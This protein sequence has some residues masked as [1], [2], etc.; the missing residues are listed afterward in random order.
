MISLYVRKAISKFL[1]E[2]L[3]SS[4]YIKIASSLASLPVQIEHTKNS[5]RMVRTSFQGVLNSRIIPFHLHQTWPYWVVQQTDP[6]NP[7]YTHTG[8]PALLLN[9]TQR[10]WTV[11]SSPGISDRAIVDPR[12]LITPYPMGW[13]LDFWIYLDKK[14]IV[15]AT[16]P[17]VTQVMA[18]NKALIQ[19]AY[20]KDTLEVMSEAFF[21]QEPDHHQSLLL[22]KVTLKN[23]G[24]LAKAFSFFFAIRPFNP[25]GISPIEDI[26]YLS[27][28]A[29]V[30]DNR[31]ALVLDQKPHNIVCL[32]FED[33]DVS[34]H[35]NSWE[36]I[37]KTKC[38]HHLGSA[39]A[40]YKVVLQPGE[41]QSFTCKLPTDPA[42]R[43]KGLMNKTLPLPQAQL[44]SHQIYHIQSIPYEDTKLQ[45]NSDWDGL[46]KSFMSV[47][48]PQSQVQNLVELNMAH[49]HSFIE[50]KPLSVSQ[51]SDK[52]SRIHDTTYL[53]FALNR[54][55]SFD[56]SKKILKSSRFFETKRFYPYLRGDRTGQLL[57]ALY[58]TYALSQ[59]IPFIEK[60]FGQVESLVK[61]IK[62]HGKN[63]TNTQQVATELKNFINRQTGREVYFFDY[64]WAVAGLKAAAKIAQALHKTEE[65]LQFNQLHQEF[66]GYLTVLLRDALGPL[67]KFEY[68]PVSTKRGVDTGLMMSLSS[69]F[70]LSVLDA[71]DPRITQ[72]LSL[73]DPYLVNGLLYSPIGT[74]GFA[75]AQNCQLAQIY[76]ARNDLRVWDIFN[77]ITQ[78]ATSTGAFPETI[79]PISGKGSAGE[80]HSSLASASFIHLFRTMLVQETDNTL[81]LFPFLQPQWLTE[82]GLSLENVPTLFGKL[83]FTLKK[84]GSKALLELSLIPIKTLQNIQVFLPKPNPVLVGT[85]TPDTTQAEFELI[86]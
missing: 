70:P 72:T 47:R 49:L 79:H 74:P 24:H 52:S 3:S 5:A 31:L 21:K 64:F 20:T 37:L 69:I 26:T 67:P 58:D 23:T 45:V 43:L 66:S 18:N 12:G 56:M 40:E 11:I 86:L 75:I 48:L 85:L 82:E 16:L 30:V 19:T 8:F 2:L 53:I 59:D 13:S 71:F 57:V 6:Q 68:I 63:W 84:A 4:F 73:L 42:S 61:K 44:L 76:M 35:I 10:N 65:V 34:E 1:T 55:G 83:S 60:H 54:I 33:G 25:E 7:S 38:Q 51:F 78:K 77:W 29:F 50:R 17:Q 80:G 32:H 39:F 28:N 27:S 41:T 15:P 81:I 22:N 36:M 9:S 62:G 14:L 46:F